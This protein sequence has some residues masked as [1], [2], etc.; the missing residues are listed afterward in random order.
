M[1]KT[2]NDENMEAARAGQAGKGFAVVADEVRNL[3]GKTAESSKNTTILIEQAMRAVKHGTSI[4]NETAW[5]FGRVAEH[6]DRVAQ[7]AQNI[8]ENSKMQDE[9][10]HQTTEGVNRI[11]NVVQTNSATAQQTAAASEELSGQA[12]MLRKLMSKFKLQT[13]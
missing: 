8:A 9:A 10:I 4:A 6:V 5:S 2:K 3:A 12:N 1:E 7:R 11:S 13:A